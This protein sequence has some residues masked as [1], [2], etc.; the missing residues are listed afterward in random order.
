MVLIQRKAQ[1]DRLRA[2]FEQ[3]DDRR[4]GQVCLI[5][6]GVGSGKTAL[7]EAFAREVTERSAQLLRAVGSRAERD[8]QFAVM[9][10]LI[11]SSGPGRASLRQV[12][13]AVRLLARAAP[14]APAAVEESGVR[15]DGTA[16][17]GAVTAEQP[18]PSSVQGMLASLFDLARPA[19]L[20]IAVDDVHHADRAS[21]QCLL[22]AVRRLRHKRIM[23]VLTESSSLRTPHPDFRAELMSQPC[24]SRIDLAPLTDEALGLLADTHPVP[25]A[26]ARIARLAPAVTGGS[27]LLMRALLDDPVASGT[28]PR[29]EAAPALGGGDGPLAQAVLRALYRHEP[30][31]RATAKTLAVLG[32]PT[33]LP[34]LARLLALTP[35][36]T[37][38]AVQLLCQCGLVDGDLLRRPLVPAVL[39]DLPAEERRRLHRRAAEVLHEYGAEP[40]VVAR[41][42]IGAEW[43]EPDWAEPALYRAATQAL[44][45]GRPDFASA[46]LGL[47]RRRAGDTGAWT[48]Y[49]SL[50][51]RARW[52]V[53]PL[54]AATDLTV[55]TA[56]EGPELGTPAALTGVPALLWHGR[57]DTARAIMAAVAQEPGLTAKT[58]TLLTAARLLTSLCRPDHSRDARDEAR[59]VTESG[60]ATSVTGRYLDALVLLADTL[61]S[62]RASA[63]AAARAEPM[64][65]RY[66][67]EDGALG[68]LAALLLVMVYAGRPGP[69]RAW[70]RT[71]L[72]R[73]S[74]RYAPTWQAVLHAI[75]AEAGLRLGS[76]EE[77]DEQARAALTV[78]TP[79]AWGVAVAAPL[80]TL[81]AAATEAGRFED[82]DR[83]LARPVPAEAF[84][85]P[86]GL[87]YLAARARYQLAAGAHRAA[88]DD[89]RWIRREMAAWQMDTAALV[90]WR[91]DLARVQIALGRRQDAVRLLE[92]QLDPARSADDGTRGRALRLL[93]GLVPPEQGRQLLARAAKLL[94]PDDR[95]EPSRPPGA[96]RPAPPAPERPA[97][98]LLGRRAGSAAKPRPERPEPPGGLSEA[99]SRVAALAAQG[100]TNRQISSKLF[101]TV[102]TVEQHLTRIYRKLDVKQRTDLATRLA[103]VGALGE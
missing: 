20:V 67:A 2:A 40:E 14:L 62:E 36:L 22:Y 74:V 30:E 4:G 96:P 55:L 27:P 17:P 52:Q 3:C 12:A 24:F 15:S 32:R 19:P 21:L 48:A 6:G 85:T 75:R 7:L 83:W 49:D 28:A 90:P 41:H 94:G 42:L 59:R 35:D 54:S 87:H 29:P 99:E 45:T 31:V 64:I 16:H 25:A 34:V 103:A 102:S 66:L 69:A 10:Q 11:D 70:A 43:A 88:A 50:L 68:L 44:D 58:R 47:T 60:T 76:P 5:T 86:L 33:P 23:V 57:G 84:R 46:C 18:L 81:V 93:A 53:N 92:D 37:A 91:L 8:L 100:H 71:L 26:R 101:I 80:G 89:L 39:A 97:V 79:Q 13:T 78:I 72:E 95:G 56:A 1:L 65:Q 63:D 51:L 9:D 73:P 61:D 98:R 38:Q 82:A 77:A